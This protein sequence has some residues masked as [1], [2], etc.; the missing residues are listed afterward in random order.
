MQFQAKPLATAGQ[1]KQQKNSLM[2]LLF[3]CMEIQF[4]I[5]ILKNM[6][7]QHKQEKSICN[8]ESK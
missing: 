8:N 4:L 6:I 7:K 5:L 2:I 3:V 1:L